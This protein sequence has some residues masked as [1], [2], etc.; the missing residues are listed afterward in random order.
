MHLLQLGGG[1]LAALGLEIDR[2]TARHPAATDGAR[3]QLDE[4]HT[5]SGIG[6]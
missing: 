5:D 3:E 2:L 1:E 6:G 4:P